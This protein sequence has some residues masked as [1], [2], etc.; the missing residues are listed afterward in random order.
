MAIILFIIIGWV[1]GL[2]A[3]VVLPGLRRMGLISMLLVSMVGAIVGG[4]FA[5][6]FNMAGPLFVPRP[7]NIAG[8][9][10]GA[11]IAVSVVYV[12]QRRQVHD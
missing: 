3:R 8:A 6:T 1:T 4:M 5:A 2:F 10:V 11:V 7:H 12:V 9:V